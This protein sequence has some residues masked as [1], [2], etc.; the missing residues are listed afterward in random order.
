VAV[1]AVA[2]A[3]LECPEV[4]TSVAPTTTVSVEVGIAVAQMPFSPLHARLVSVA[5][6]NVVLRSK[7]VPVPILE[8]VPAVPT[9]EF[10]VVAVGADVPPLR[11][12]R[13]E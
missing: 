5:A 13:A 2:V 10:E 7:A 12:K 8:P 4:L 11:E 9:A 1:A 6:T 3:T